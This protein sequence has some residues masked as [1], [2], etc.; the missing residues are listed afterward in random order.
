MNRIGLLCVF[1]FPPLSVASVFDP[2]ELRVTPSPTQA[3]QIRLAAGV[4]VLDFDLSPAGPRVALLTADASGGRQVLFWDIGRPQ[5]AKIWDAPAGFA[6]R[7]IVWHPQAAALFLSGQQ[8]QRYVIVKLEAKAG[9]WNAH[10]IYSSRQEIR[11]LVA[12]PRPYVALDYEG[13]QPPPPVYRLFFGLRG[14]DG[15]YSVHSIT[16]EGKRDYQVIGRKEGFTKFP[17]A[18]VNPSEL[19]AA[20][21]LPV[22]FHPAGQLFIW[23]DSGNCFH[24]AG[25]GRDHWETNAR[26]FG[27]D[28]CGGTISATPNG[29]GVLQWRS[30]VDGFDLLL[31]QGATRRTE[32]TGFR[33]ISAPS[34]VPDGRGIVG[35][36]RAGSV[37]VVN[38]VPLQV[39]LADVVNAWM[40]SESAHDTQ[41]LTGYGGLFRELKDDQLYQL[42]DSEAYYCGHLDESTPTRPYLVTSDSFWELFAAAYEGIFIVRERQLA[43]PAFW[44]FVEQASASLRQSHPQSPWNAVFAAL[45]ALESK[46]ESNEEAQRVIRAGS[47]QFSPVA[48]RDFDYGEL[49]PRGHYTATPESR[50]YFQAFRYLTRVADPKWSTGELRQLPAPVKN[51]AQRWIAAYEGLIAP[52]RSPFLWQESIFQPPAF[53]KHPQIVPVLFPLSWGFDNEI[54]FSTTYHS[55]LPA[56]E[57]I[58]GPG[59]LRLSPSGIDIAAALG[60]GFARGLLSSEIKKYPPLNDALNA[61]ANRYRAAPAGSNLYEQWID[62]LAVQWADSVAS[63][64]GELDAALWRAKRLQTGLASWATLRHATVL[65]NELVSAECGEAGFEEIILRPPRGYVEP[66]PQTFGK[67]ADLFAATVKLV[68][69]GAKGLSGVLPSEEV[70]KDQLRV[71][72]VRRL[73][74]TADKARLFQSM[75]AKETR[76][77]LLSASDYEEILYFGRVAEH[78]FLIYKSLANKDL[79]LSTPDP[80]PK[81]A[82]ISDVEGHAPYGV[83]A[84]GRPLEWD[85]IVPF[86]G[87]HELVKGASYS[88]YEF[89]SDKLLDDSEWI[90]KVA[91]QPHPAWIAPYLSGNNLSCP[92]RNP[93]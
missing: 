37:S 64:N 44:Q 41:L 6:A 62:A 58:E 4:H 47:P 91:A 84:V 60:S 28:V 89:L 40:F 35:V 75:A 22:G 27:R 29:A 78:H 80:V 19:V 61:L 87:R 48:G 23:E 66:D 77:E 3:S 32:A 83:V 45:A 52:S 67:I 50:R 39:P 56:A 38:Y 74:E 63:P 79:A 51:A 46:P 92:P 11:R 26:L 57:R 2:P 10:E 13:T 93:F 20:S 30:G 17:N 70:T 7:S 71:G 25:Y 5:T 9:A 88:Y 49:K 65:V 8:G 18:D 21:A 43:I 24:I 55:A 31:D 34:S 82:D 90:K 73:N 76:N 15:S 14:H 86:F 59:G 85:H 68:S 81:L 42:Y 1:L 72:L 33:L 53:I 16:E 12:G 69:S 36:T 54:L